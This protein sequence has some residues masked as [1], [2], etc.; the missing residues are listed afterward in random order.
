M[1]Q[2]GKAFVEI[3][4]HNMNRTQAIA[5]V[6]AAIKRAGSGTYRITVIHGYNSGTVLRDA[7]R[8]HCR[9]HP[10]VKRVEIG[11]NQGQTDL[12]MREL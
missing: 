3:D 4:V 8:A 10:L 7:I 9:N 6:D 1:K 5:A 12:I 11:L 2:A